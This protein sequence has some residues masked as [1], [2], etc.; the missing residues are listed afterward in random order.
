MQYRIKLKNSEECVILDG[1]VY[2][3]LATDPHLVKIKFF[4]NLRQHSS[5]RAVFQKTRKTEAGRYATGTGP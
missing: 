1:R 4:A 5:G 3:Q 2:D